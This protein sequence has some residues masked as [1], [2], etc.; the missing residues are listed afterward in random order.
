MGAVVA[1]AGLVAEGAAASFGPEPES[2]QPARSRLAPARTAA[3]VA[4]RMAPA[5]KRRVLERATRW[6]ERLFIGH[7]GWRCDG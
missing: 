3:R 6:E 1:A 2:P 7:S 5:E 4:G